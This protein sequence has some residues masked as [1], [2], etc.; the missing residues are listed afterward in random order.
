MKEGSLLVG[1]LQM[2]GERQVCSGASEDCRG[3]KGGV[4]LNTTRTK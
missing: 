1:P 3:K 4:L 2:L